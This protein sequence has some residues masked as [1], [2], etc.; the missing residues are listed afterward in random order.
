MI[1]KRKACNSYD[2]SIFR[3]YF[4]LPIAAHKKMFPAAVTN[5]HF[6]SYFFTNGVAPQCGSTNFV[7]FYKIYFTFN[8]IFR[9]K[10]LFFELLQTATECGSARFYRKMFPIGMGVFPTKS[11]K[12]RVTMRLFPEFPEF[13]GFLHTY[14]K[15]NICSFFSS[16]STHSVNNCE[17]SS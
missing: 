12:S 9:K 14:R 2:S 4:F 1:E 6:C 17:L 13:P 3:C 15:K 8:L 16:S 11:T 5:S 7:L 10:Q